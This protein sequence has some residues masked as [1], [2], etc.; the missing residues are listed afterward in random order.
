MCGFRNDE[1]NPFKCCR[2]AFGPSFSTYVSAAFSCGDRRRT[3][4]DR[5]NT[6]LRCNDIAP[7]TNDHN[8]IH[9]HRTRITQMYRLTKR[10]WFTNVRIVSQWVRRHTLD[11][12]EREDDQRPDWARLFAHANTP[13]YTWFSAT[14]YGGTS[15]QRTSDREN[16]HVTTEP[17]KFSSN[18]VSVARNEN[19]I[20]PIVKPLGWNRF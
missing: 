16:H 12:T 17:W 19:I 9:R 20:S 15:V 8:S 11:P 14:V 18:N 13:R 3:N 5:Q 2:S 6:S 1:A 10:E 4:R 7:Y